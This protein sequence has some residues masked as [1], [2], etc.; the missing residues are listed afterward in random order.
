MVVFCRNETHTPSGMRICLI[1]SD[2]PQ[3]YG[4]VTSGPRDW[5]AAGL[6]LVALALHGAG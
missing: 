3:T 1:D 6:V 4:R 5:S 2:K